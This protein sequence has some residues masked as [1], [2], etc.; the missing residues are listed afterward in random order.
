MHGLFPAP[1]LSRGAIHGHRHM[2]LGSTLVVL[3]LVPMWMNFLLRTI[4]WMSLLENNGV[5][6]T[7]LEGWA[8]A[9]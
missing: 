2:K 4:A 3:I 9:R 1:R 5:I 7:F 6:N 8:C